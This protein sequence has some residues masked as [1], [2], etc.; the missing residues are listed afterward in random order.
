MTLT[1]QMNSMSSLSMSFTTMIF[2]LLR[3]CRARSLSASLSEDS[4]LGSNVF[5]SLWKPASVL[6]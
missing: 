5:H 6:V 1:L 4:L 2:I 3:K